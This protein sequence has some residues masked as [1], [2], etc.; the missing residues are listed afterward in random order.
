MGVKNGEWGVSHPL[1]PWQQIL[2]PFHRPV[3]PSHMCDMLK[4]R[5]FIDLQKQASTHPAPPQTALQPDQTLKLFK[6]RSP[7]MCTAL[8]L[9]GTS[10]WWWSL[11]FFAVCTLPRLRGWGQLH[12]CMRELSS[13]CNWWERFLLST[14]PCPVPRSAA[15]NE[16]GLI[17]LYLLHTAYNLGDEID[18]ENKRCYSILLFIWLPAKHSRKQSV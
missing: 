14:P 17:F 6:P 15:V 9:V 4:L 2:T 3:G 1:H 12:S 10:P 8:V 5:I 13:W 16:S 18:Q 7:F 11:C